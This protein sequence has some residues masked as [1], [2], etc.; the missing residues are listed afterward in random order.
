MTDRNDFAIPDRSQRGLDEDR[1]LPPLVTEPEEEPRDDVA[2]PGREAAHRLSDRI[3]F[4]R[5][6]P[7]EY[8]E[9]RVDL[10]RKTRLVRMLYGE[11]EQSG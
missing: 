1:G 6:G 8:D 7:V 5:R 11:A 2:L 3:D 10:G 4:L 9:P